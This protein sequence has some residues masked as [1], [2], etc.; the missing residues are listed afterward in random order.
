VR[1]EAD[2]E[3]SAIERVPRDVAAWRRR[4]MM[5]AGFATDLAA[6]LAADPGYDLHDLLDLVDHGCPPRLAAR[7]L[8][9]L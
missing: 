5:N 6:D 4:M 7:I 1:A 2:N 3:P 9:P 8:A